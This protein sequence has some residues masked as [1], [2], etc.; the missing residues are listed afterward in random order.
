MHI[1]DGFLSLP[2]WATMDAIALP[3]VAVMARQAQKHLDE[4]KIPLLGVMG[5]FVFAAQ[6]INFPV[7][8]G[9]S[10]H[11]VGAALLAIALGPAAS[12]VVL[13]SI[14]V[15]QALVFQDGGVVSLGANVMNMAIAGSLA[16]YLPYRL[17]GRTR[18]RKLGIFL[19]GAFSVGVAATM[20]LSE[21]LVS[22]V[23][24]SRSV[25]WVSIA[26]FAVSAILEGAITLAVVESIEKI[27]PE[28]VRRPV[29]VRSPVFVSVAATALL[30]AGVGVLFASQAP[31]GLQRLG[32]ET[33]LVAR[34]KAWIATPFAGYELHGLDTVWLQR[35]L[36]GLAGVVMIYVVCLVIGHLI[37]RRRTATAAGA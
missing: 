18:R 27:H 4:S 28:W 31:D 5:A 33:G 23:R 3:S 29:A 10:G 19:S 37:A 32:Q 16:G 30:L 8:P 1:P 17:L 25:L 12:S 7:G 13:T 14:L 11:L 15:I 21:L 9:T 24:M 2:V 34:A 26:L 35:A 36:A 22:G 6:M 20:A